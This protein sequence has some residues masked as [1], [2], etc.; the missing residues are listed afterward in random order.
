MLRPT[1]IR[2]LKM[3]LAVIAI[4]LC[5]IGLT[6]GSVASIAEVNRPRRGNAFFLS[7]AAITIAICTMGL[8]W[9]WAIIIAI[10]TSILFPML[11]AAA[12][13]GTHSQ[14]ALDNM[15]KFGAEGYSE[16]KLIL[17]VILGMVLSI[18][19]ILLN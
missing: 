12:I 7:I 1:R 17:W 11:F 14:W 6:L 3:I 2:V 4:I 16:T 8:S 15:C 9:Y 13:S 5:L 19:S 18:I 10:P